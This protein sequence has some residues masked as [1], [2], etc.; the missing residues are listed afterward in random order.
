MSAVAKN[1]VKQI[2]SAPSKDKLIQLRQLQCQVFK[3]TYN[4]NNIRTGAKILRA[5]LRGQT[6]ANYYGPSDFPS[7]AKVARSLSTPDFTVINAPEV[8]RAERVEDLKRRGKGSPKKIREAASAGKKK[9][10]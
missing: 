3:E 1:A 9:K 5:P 4:P 10:K 7:I 2:L 8:Y 6:L